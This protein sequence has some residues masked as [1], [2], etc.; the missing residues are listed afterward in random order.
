MISAANPADPFGWVAGRALAEVAIARV[1]LLTS[2]PTINTTDGFHAASTPCDDGV[3]HNG[4]SSG[5]RPCY[6]SVSWMTAPVTVRMPDLRLP[7]EALPG[8]E[9][10]SDG[11]YVLS[12][13]ERRQRQRHHTST[14]VGRCPEKER[15]NILRH[16]RIVR[17][18]Q[19]A[20]R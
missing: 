10:H 7:D 2:M 16:A 5:T 11:G 13:A 8:S 1:R 6:A 4:S 14:G 20:R 19:G 18:S 17:K 15:H 9:L 3:L 12:G